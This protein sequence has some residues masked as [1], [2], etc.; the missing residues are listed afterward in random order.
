MLAATKEQQ[1]SRNQS[2]RETAMKTLSIIIVSYNTKAVLRECLKKIQQYNDGIDYEVLVVDNDSRDGS[3]KM[4][5]LEFPEVR[6]TCSGAN[7]GFAGGNN[8]ALR[9][10]RGKYLLLLNS[11]AYLLPGTLQSTIDYMENDRECGILGVKLVGEDGEMQPS[12][13][14]LPNPLNKLAVMSGLAS[15]F[16][17]AP[18]IGSPDY[19]TWA[20]DH[21]RTVGWVPGAYFLIRREVCEEIGLLDDRYFM[22][23]EEVDFCR[24][25]ASYG[26]KTCFF[27]FA[28]VVHLGGESSKT[29][30][31]HMSKS[32]KQLLGIRL[33]S[34]YRYYRKHY[35][36]AGVIATAAVEIG[37]KALVWF[38]NIIIA[39]KEAALKIEDAE[40][41]IVAIFKI[42]RRDSFGK[43]ANVMK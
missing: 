40:I 31:Q 39:G 37:W 23:F 12:A 19:A 33:E 24:N 28:A 14:K 18:L 10:A 42:L 22:Y 4:V 30:R 17:G 29:T 38:K 35:G 26:W 34:E 9:E 16:P 8:I 41:T 13:R 6:L 2:N 43:T 25:A 21:V 5:E 1:I 11:D 32:G 36:L 3:D 15:R 7:L 27:P 20:H